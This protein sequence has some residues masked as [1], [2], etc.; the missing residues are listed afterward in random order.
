MMTKEGSTNMVNFMIP[1]AGVFM[2]RRGHISH[3]GEYESSSN[4][5]LYCN[6]TLLDKGNIMVLS[7]AIVDFYLFYDGAVDMQI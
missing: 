2:L 5:S 3:Y 1:G 6:T 7:Y 4:L